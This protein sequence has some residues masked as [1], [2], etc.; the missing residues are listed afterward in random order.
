M[1]M[2]FGF[3]FLA[4][5]MVEG[6]ILGLREDQA[7]AL[8]II[9]PLTGP[10]LLVGTIFCLAFWRNPRRSVVLWLTLTL[11]ALPAL[12]YGV[13]VVGFVAALSLN[14]ALFA[15]FG[16][17]EAR[18]KVLPLLRWALGES[19]GQVPHLVGVV[20]RAMPI[21]LTAMILF[22]FTAEI[23]QMSR[24]L[25]GRFTFLAPGA[26]FLLGLLAQ[27][28]HLARL[29]ANYCQPLDAEGWAREEEKLKDLAQDRP[30]LGPLQE[31]AVP[32]EERASRKM[33]GRIKLNIFLLLVFA[34]NLQ[35]LATCTS[36]V[37][38]ILLFGVLALPLD[39][40]AAFA[41]ATS[42]SPLTE[43]YV[44]E[45]LG[46][47]IILTNALLEVALFLAVFAYLS[48]VLYAAHSDTYMHDFL[49]H[50]DARIK[51]AVLVRRFYECI[52]WRPRMRPWS[53]SEVQLDFL[54]PDGVIAEKASLV[55]ATPDGRGG[56]VDMVNDGK[57]LRTR[58]RES[59][60]GTLIYHYVVDEDRSRRDWEV[61]EVI[62]ESAG[63]E[64]SLLKIGHSRAR[65]S[66]SERIAQQVAPPAPGAVEPE[67]E[68]VA[69]RAAE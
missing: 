69:P 13:D 66:A 62:T 61:D 15:L 6:V 16:L 51:S 40:Q 26:L 60:G 67:A 31:L 68:P 54:I 8:A 25:D 7:G 10:A 46:R 33:P 41:G 53:R 27:G 59:L 32:R 48:F 24:G 37:F 12:L 30:E 5:L 4:L 42:E 39:T 23:W 11:P 65:P 49:P 47:E 14:L 36:L 2:Y 52:F 55:W 19:L 3:I 29:V 20:A 1:S 38:F 22:F 64:K 9:A 44:Q 34:Q 28:V 57:T 50:I 17:L 63:V 21:L 56:T 43:I 35:L 18:I 45:F 58:L